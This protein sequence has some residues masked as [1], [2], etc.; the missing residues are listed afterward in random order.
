MREPPRRWGGV[1]RRWRREVEGGRMMW[2]EGSGGALG[3]RVDLPAEADDPVA[4]V[5]HPHHALLREVHRHPRRRPHVLQHRHHLP[6]PLPPHSRALSHSGARRA[7]KEEERLRWV[8]GG[9]G[10]GMAKEQT[11]SMRQSRR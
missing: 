2:W 7:R 6:R 5:Q 9:G 11:R 1:R 4:S 3:G 8:E 10:T